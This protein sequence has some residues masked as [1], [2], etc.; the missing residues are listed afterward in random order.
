MT[1]CD[2]PTVMIDLCA[3]CGADLRKEV[4][5]NNVKTKNVTEASV[6]MLHSIP[7]LKVSPKLAKKIG[8]EDEQRLLQ[9]KKLALLVDLDQTIIHTTMENV[10]VN[11]KVMKARLSQ[12]NYFII[13]LII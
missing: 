13:L 4:L 11:I 1:G 3:Q 7:E 2:H 5:K 10:P 6:P 9:D 12:K 8:K